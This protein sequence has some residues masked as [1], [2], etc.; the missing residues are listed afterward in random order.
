VSF[1]NWLGVLALLIYF[2][3][4]LML[5]IKR[6]RSFYEKLGLIR[7]NITMIMFL[8]MMGVIIKIVLRLMFNIRYVLQTPWFNI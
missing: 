4:G 7:Y 8:I 6:C 3:G 2:G 1:P 5:P